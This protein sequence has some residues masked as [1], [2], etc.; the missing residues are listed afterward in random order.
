MPRTRSLACRIHL[1]IWL[2]VGATSGLAAEQGLVWKARTDSSLSR[3]IEAADRVA[4]S[5]LRQRLLHEILLT[6]SPESGDREALVGVVERLEDGAVLS[7]VARNR[8][9]DD[10]VRRAAIARL[11]DQTLLAA[12]ARDDDDDDVRGAALARLTD[13]SLMVE[14]L[15]STAGCGPVYVPASG[16]SWVAGREVPLAPQVAVVSATRLL[17]GDVLLEMAAPGSPPAVR[18]EAVS[19]LEDVRVLQRIALTDADHHLRFAALRRLFRGPADETARASATVSEA[20]RGAGP[21]FRRAL[22]DLADEDLLSRIARDPEEPEEIRIRALLSVRDRSLVAELASTPGPVPLRIAAVWWLA[23]RGGEDELARLLPGLQPPAVRAAAERALG[24][25]QVL[26]ELA[27]LDEEARREKVGTIRD[28]A[29]LARIARQDPS[30]GV[31]LAARE[32]LAYGDLRDAIALEHLAERW[33]STHSTGG[34]EDIRDPRTL[35]RL[36]STHPLSAVRE[37]ALA[38]ADPGLLRETLLHEVDDSTLRVAVRRTTDTELLADLAPSFPAWARG[39][40]MKRLP[41][42]ALVEI[43]GSAPSLVTRL[44]AVEALEDPAALAALARS[45]APRRVRRAAIERTSSPSVLAEIVRTETD[46]DLRTA[47]AERISG[48]A[49]LLGLMRGETDPLVRAALVARLTDLR[50]LVEIAVDDSEPVEV[51]VAAVRALGRHWKT[52]AMARG[53]REGDEGACRRLLGRARDA[54]DAWD[55]AQAARWLTDPAAVGRIARSDM[56][57]AVRLAAAD[58]IEDAT[59]RLAVLFAIA[60]TDCTKAAS[61]RI[62]DPEIAAWIALDW[63]PDVAA[64]AAWQVTDPSVLRELALVRGGPAGQVAL[65]RLGDPRL[66]ARV[67]RASRERMSFDMIEDREQLRELASS[68]RQRENRMEACAKLGDPRLLAGLAKGS[69][70]KAARLT[71]IVALQDN[72]VLAEIATGTDTPDVRESA[73]WFLDDQRVLSEIARQDPSL[74]VRRAAAAQLEDGPTLAALVA[75]E[76]QDEG[77]R[78]AALDRLDRHRPAHPYELSIEALWTR[79][80]LARVTDDALLKRLVYSQTDSQAR[81]YVLRLLE[82]RGGIDAATWQELALG[83][84]DKEVRHHATTMVS[85]PTTLERVARFDQE[86]GVRKAAVERIEAQSVLVTVLGTD[87]EPEV[88]SAA[89]KRLD[90]DTLLSVATGDAWVAARLSAIDELRRR[91]PDASAPTLLDLAWHDPDPEVRTEII[92]GLPQTALA[93]LAVE[94]PDPLARRAAVQRLDDETLLLRLARSGQ[95]PVLLRIA[96]V[97]RLEDPAVLSELAIG[98]GSRTVALSAARR[99]GLLRRCRSNDDGSTD[100][101]LAGVAQA[102]QDVVVREL[103][104][105]ALCD[106]RALGRLAGRSES[107]RAVQARRRAEERRRRAAAWAMVGG[108]GLEVGSPLGVGVSAPGAL[109]TGAGGTYH[110]PSGRLGL[111]YRGAS[112]EL[113]YRVGLLGGT[114]LHNVGVIPFPLLDVTAGGLLFQSFDRNVGCPGTCWGLKVDVGLFSVLRVGHTRLWPSGGGRP[115]DSWHVA[116]EVPLWWRGSGLDF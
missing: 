11:S 54:K 76:G 3:R 74:A 31:R 105:A 63:G 81:R 113:G 109:I 115:N 57:P 18:Q 84:G 5:R 98:S 106:H 89:A 61:A 86:T 87:P 78:L 34:I 80:G 60:A 114:Y 30:L 26:P 21:R 58:R 40:A 104:Y 64:G 25:A 12:I 75:D 9:L 67:V 71:A 52:W 38:R 93:R 35:A 49:V 72:P 28:A 23:R 100:Q 46:A 37:A 36:A 69:P 107:A 83:H 79:E 20:M 50:R 8:R 47:A 111:G 95:E 1:T 2:A 19:A 62:A 27:D 70:W 94:H 97:Q 43:A 14:I 55:R 22:L 88:R 4:D 13:R 73:V 53:C 108:L 82:S 85:D 42:A 66:A 112:A 33:A 48:K 90:L 16:A 96:A 59:E 101:T 24:Q 44:A 116:I 17:P 99:I 68:A 45:D 102:S 29:L 91:S 51:Q 77:V 39:A 6:A 110:G 32:R 103:V 15:R 41:Q 65:Q 7:R 10:G 56:S 92:R